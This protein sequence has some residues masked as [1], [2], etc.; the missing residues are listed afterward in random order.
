MK[1]FG[2]RSGI[3]QHSL[4]SMYFHGRGVAQDYAEALRWYHMAAEQGHAHAGVALSLMY[5]AGL[6]VPQDY[7]ETD[8]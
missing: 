3:N 1:L 6:G 7:S 5:G 4:G 8:H 2:I